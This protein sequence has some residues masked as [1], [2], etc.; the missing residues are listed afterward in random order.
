L[1]VNGEALDLLGV[2]N[3]HIPAVLFERVVDEASACHRLDDPAHRLAVPRDPACQAANTIVIAGH[4]E[5]LDQLAVRGQ[6][7]D[8]EPLATQIQSS[9]QHED[10]PP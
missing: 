6:Q 5:L 4:G 2:G 9:V 8:V 7:A 1:Q 10:G 3:Q